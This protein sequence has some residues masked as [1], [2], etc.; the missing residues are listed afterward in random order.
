MMRAAQIHRHPDLRRAYLALVVM[1][2]TGAHLVSEFSGMGLAAGRITLSP[3]HYYLGAGLLVALVVLARDLSTLFS[4]ASNRRDAKRLA[5]IGLQS[6]PFAGKRGFLTITSC[7]QFAVGWTTV[8][9]EGS[10]LLC[11]D[12]AAGA[13]G[14]VFTAFVLSLFLK[15]I[16]RRL[17]D[18][19]QAVIEFCIAAA[20]EPQRKANV[21]QPM[22]AARA[23]DIWSSRLFNRPPPLLQSA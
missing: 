17:P 5:E 12:V 11:H 10:P 13:I 3:L 8:V 16:T 20:R 9:A 2:G 7:L 15:A 21:E 18:I 22:L 4:N 23:Q 19:A 1:G 6:L 14:A